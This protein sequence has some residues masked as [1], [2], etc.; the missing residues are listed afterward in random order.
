MPR[1]NRVDPFGNLI[2]TTPRGTLM[3]NRGCLHDDQ[4]II[5]K[6][7]ARKAWVTCRLEWKG[8]RRA[9]F[10]PGRYSELFFLD[11]ATAFAAG[12]RP[13][14]DCRSDDY[15]AFNLAFSKAFASGIKVKAEAMDQQIHSDRMGHNNSKRTFTAELSDM[16]DGVIVLLEGEPNSP[17]ML[18]KGQLFCW[19]FEGYS[20]PM[21]LNEIGMVEVLTP[22]SICAVLTAGY[23]V[24]VHH[25]AMAFSDELLR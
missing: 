21:P 8:I 14:N 15:K 24:K 19:T 9:V 22:A 18:W 7:F 4:G 16:P 3:G 6:A 25:S 10:A 5:R 20:N 11:E 23:P 17:R 2:T 12:H 1:Q 13:C